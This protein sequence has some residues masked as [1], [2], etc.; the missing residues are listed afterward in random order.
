VWAIYF[1][2]LRREHGFRS[3]RNGTMGKAGGPL[4]PRS[5]FFTHNRGSASPERFGPGTL[6]ILPPDSFEAGPPLAGAIDTAHLVSKTA[7]TPLARVEVTPADFPFAGRIGYHRD[8]EPI[9]VSLLRG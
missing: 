7:V 5:Y 8:R 3:T 1:A 2:C 9:F 4:Y 6:Y